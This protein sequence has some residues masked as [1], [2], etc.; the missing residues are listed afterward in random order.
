M[1]SSSESESVGSVPSSASSESVRPSLSLSIEPII[2]VVV[3]VLGV[4]DVS[5]VE[6]DDDVDDDGV[7]CAVV[8]C[9]A[10]LGLVI[11]KEVVIATLVVDDEVVEDIVVVG[12][13]VVEGG[14]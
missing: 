8:V 13:V 1:S 12:V 7:I 9:G 14:I 2:V 10:V 3:R 11:V 4:E 6:V 5:G